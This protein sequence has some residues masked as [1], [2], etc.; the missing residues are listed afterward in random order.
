[1]IRK[2]LKKTCTLS[3]I[4]IHSGLQVELT[5]KPAAAGSGLCFF[6]TDAQVCIPV[7]PTYLSSTARATLLENNGSF[8]KTPEHLLAACAGLGITDLLIEISGE[9]IPILD[10]SSLDFVN[11]FQSAEIVSIEGDI[12]P[13]IITK[14]CIVSEDGAMVIALPHPTSRYTYTL[15]YPHTFIGSQVSSWELSSDIF[16][17]EIAPARTYGFFKEVEALLKQGLARGGS[18]DNAVIIGDTEYMT[19]LRFPD[20]LARHKLLDLIGDMAVLNRPIQG[21]ILGIKSGHALN[22]KMVKFLASQ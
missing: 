21:H 20:E 2:T 19:P 5:L 9:E 10:G 6:R 4:G 3:G 8:I 16:E 15:D 13:L 22:A 12:H 7:H 1:M 18:I 11:A 17:T 14:P